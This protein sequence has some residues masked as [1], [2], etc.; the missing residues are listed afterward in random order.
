V[1]D[2]PDHEKAQLHHLLGDVD[3]KMGDSVEAVREYQRAAELNSSEANFFDWGAELLIHH[4]AEPAIEVFTKGNRL[5]PRSVRMLAALGTAWYSLGSYD[6]AVQ[7][8]CAASDLNPDDPNPYLFMG[9]MQAAENTRSASIE[10]RLSRF[11]ALQPENALANYYYAVSLWQVRKSPEDPV[12]SQ[13]KAVLEKAVRLDSKLGVAYLQL[14]IVYAEQKN[15]PKAISAYQQ[16]VEATPSLEQAHYRLAQAYR[17]A[18]ETA[19][20]QAELQVYEKI[21]REKQQEIERQRHELQQFVYR[22]RDSSPASQQQ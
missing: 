15:L 1:P 5:F 3:E 16:A 4:A 21:L 2:K 7:N 22:L 13:A 18:G 14:G 9:K 10:E 20:A 12:A 6:Q 8:F 11:V 17:Q 19:Q